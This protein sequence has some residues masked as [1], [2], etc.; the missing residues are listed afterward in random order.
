LGVRGPHALLGV[1]ERRLFVIKL[2]LTRQ[3]DPPVSDLG[4]VDEGP[5][6]PLAVQ[7]DGIGHGGHDDDLQKRWHEGCEQEMAVV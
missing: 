3:R 2:E 6:I 1:S 7:P 5:C 4:H